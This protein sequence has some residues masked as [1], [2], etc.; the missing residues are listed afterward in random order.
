MRHAYITKRAAP[1]GCWAI[2]RPLAELLY[3]KG[4]AITL[5]GS[6]VSSF[7]VCAG[8][9][10]GCTIDNAEGGHFSDI[11]EMFAWNVPPELGRYVV[12]YVKIIDMQQVLNDEQ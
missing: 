7:H 8:W 10:L 11:V 2:T 6:N 1:D 5:C 4:I 3:N 9:L 12:Y